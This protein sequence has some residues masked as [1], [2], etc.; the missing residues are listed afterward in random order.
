MIVKMRKVTFIGL[1]AEKDEFLRR[2]QA[3]GV[4][5]LILPSDAAEP[6]E[7][8]KELGRVGE[9]RRFLAKRAPKQAEPVPG[10]EYPALVAQREELGEREG[11]LA[12]ELLQLKKER[13][14]LAVYGDFDPEAVALLRAK[15]LVV[16]FYRASAKTMAALDLSGVHSLVTGQERG[17]TAFVTLGLADPGLPLIPERLP[18]RGLAETEALIAAKEAELADIQA[19]YAELAKQVKALEEAQAEL[20]DRVAFARAALNLEPEL[21]DRLFVLACWSAIPEADLVKEIGSDLRYHYIAEDPQ[22]DD[23]VPVLLSN[24]PL[25]APG[26]DLVQ[27]YSHPN[28]SDFDPSGLVLYCFVI[29]YGMIIGD[30]GY[31]V[32]LGGLTLWLKSK[33]KNPAPVV[34]R[35]LFMNGLLSLST[36]F[37]GVITGSYFGVILEPGNPLLKPVLMDFGTKEGM[38][39]VMLISIIMGMVHLTIALAIKFKRT[40]DLPSLGWILVLW[41]GYVFLDAKMVSNTEAPIAQWVLIAGLALV[42]LFTSKHKNPIIRVLAGLNGA[43][44]AVQLFADVLSYMRLFALGLAT[45]YMCQTFNM[46]GGMVRD[47]VPVVGWVFMALVLVLGHTINLGL[48]IMGGVV[49]GLRLNFLEWYRWCFEGDGLIFRP[50]RLTARRQA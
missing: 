30:F 28:Y 38:N 44:G 19:Q 36:M 37:F 34:K 27:V 23:R 39:Q 13:A 46:L 5:H 14:Q 31:G 40:R 35:L 49:H 18:A 41:G 20:T 17:E 29:F 11:R 43:M 45:M 15:G 7:L 10:G 48:G 6:G 4:T 2:L 24:Q 26:E 9:V 3:T 42:V 32:V 33:L 8:I 50:F 25:F 1:M 22:E 12:N 47:A 16:N 21:D